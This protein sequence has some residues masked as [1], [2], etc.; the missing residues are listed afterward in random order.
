MEKICMLTIIATSSKKILTEKIS[1]KKIEAKMVIH[2][3]EAVH[4]LIF[5]AMPLPSR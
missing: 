1:T 3:K 5:I 2:N 4:T